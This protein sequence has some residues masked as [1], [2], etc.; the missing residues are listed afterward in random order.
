MSTAET[1][2]KCSLVSCVFHALC[3][4]FSSFWVIG[5]GAT[6]PMTNSP[7]R[8]SSYNPCP[9]NKK[10]IIVNGSPLTT[11]LLSIY[12]ITKNLNCRVTFFSTHCIFQE[13]VT[14]RMIGLARERN[15][16]YYPEEMNTGKDNQS[17]F[18]YFLKDSPVPYNMRFGFTTSA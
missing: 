11:N 15:G 10:V 4:S 12:Q 3:S 14:G 8:F 13:Q 18:S 1:T 5:L 2:S 9:R 6:G 17:H 16:L 7:T